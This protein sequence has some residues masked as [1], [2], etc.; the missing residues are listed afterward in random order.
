[1]WILIT[2]RGLKLLGDVV[3]TRM[4]EQL[5]PTEGGGLALI[6]LTEEERCAL[7][8]AG[9]PRADII[10]A[11]ALRYAELHRRGLIPAQEKPNEEPD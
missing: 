9:A 3:R 1:M 2:L 5:I 10:D 7:D 4:R 8:D 6:A 11:A